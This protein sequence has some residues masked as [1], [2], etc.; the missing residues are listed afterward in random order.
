M[1]HE[2]SGKVY[3][4]WVGESENKKFADVSSSKMIAYYGGKSGKGKRIDIEFSNRYY[5]FKV[6]IRNKQSGVYP[7]HIM[8]DY[9]SLPAIGKTIL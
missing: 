8:L 4:W 5:K 2:L 7:S 1:I 9:E 3:Y 6:N